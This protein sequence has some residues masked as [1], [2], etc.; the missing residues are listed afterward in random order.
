MT[1]PAFYRSL[2]AI[3]LLATVA[4]SSTEFVQTWTAPDAAPLRLTGSK[5]VAV[6][7]TRKPALRRSA[8]DALA[9]EITSRGAQGVASYTILPDELVRDEKLAQGT[10]E[11]FGMAGSVTMRV[12][13]RETQYSYTPSYWGGYPYY[14]SYWGGY[15]GW[16]WGAV[17]QP[18]YLTAENVVSIESL[19][20]SFRQNK[21]I[22]A[23]I[24]KTVSPESVDQTVSEL[25]SEI[26]SKL[27]DAGLL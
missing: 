21:L 5:V 16:G 18:G 19:V 26:S 12:V 13:G 20:Y 7:M 4:C 22:F 27:K 1:K 15:W 9:R 11:K 2:V 17:Y 25:A 14:G 8:E 3:A 6:F 24:S 10:F 23:G